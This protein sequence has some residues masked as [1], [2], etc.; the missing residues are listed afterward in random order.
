LPLAAAALLLILM[1]VLPAAGFFKFAWNQ[2][3]GALLAFEGKHV[4]ETREDLKLQIAD[5]AR[6][7][8]A[9]VYGPKWKDVAKGAI[10]EE[11]RALGEES[12][13]DAANTAGSTDVLAAWKPVYNDASAALRYE[14]SRPG[15]IAHRNLSARLGPFALIGG[16]LM[17]GALLRWMRHCASHLFLSDLVSIVPPF[18]DLMSEIQAVRKDGRNL[19]IVTS[20]QTQEDAI[21]VLIADQATETAAAGVRS[22]SR[23]EPAGAAPDSTFSLA[24]AFRNPRSRLKTLVRLEQIAAGG[25]GI[26]FSRVEP[27]TFLFREAFAAA[28]AGGDSPQAKLAPLEEWERR[29]WSD[30]LER[31]LVVV[32][33]VVSDAAAEGAGATSDPVCQRVRREALYWSLWNSC[34]KVEKLVLVHVAEE[35]FANPRQTQTVERL[36]RRGLLV[37][38]PYLRPFDPDFQQF[39]QQAYERKTIAE[40]ERPAR[41]IGWTQTRWIL[42]IMVVTVALFL[43]GTQRQALTPA[44]SFVSTLTAAFAGILKLIS[45]AT[46][47]HSVTE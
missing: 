24:D 33:P 20:S 1:S 43:I 47:K 29:R 35:G 13:F 14:E 45:E 26:V 25:N 19:L 38:A 12:P 28:P 22:D 10:D 6:D 18:P 7:R 16:M 23:T 15:L 9:P 34:S 31:F 39:I 44:V 4:A 42:A 46:P 41:G 5:L 40:W 11:E 3:L 17:I 8:F 21:R 36:L 30:V 32:V 27:A 2:E 37:I